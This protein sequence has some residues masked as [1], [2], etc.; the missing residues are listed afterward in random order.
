MKSLHY[1][2]D[3]KLYTFIHFSNMSEQILTPKP[4]LATL[5]ELEVGESRIYPAATSNYLKSACSNFGFQWN[6]K[7][8]TSNNRKDHTITVTRVM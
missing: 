6:K 5:R 3:I 8:T 7:F 4:L 1:L 2:C